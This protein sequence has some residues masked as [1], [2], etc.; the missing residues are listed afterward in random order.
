MYIFC[1][2]FNFLIAGPYIY[3]HK[4]ILLIKI[5]FC[6]SAEVREK[7]DL[8]DTK[9]DDYFFYK[10]TSFLAPSVAHILKFWSDTPTA[11]LRICWGGNLRKKNN[12]GQ[13]KKK[14]NTIST[15]KVGVK[16][17]LQQL[18]KKKRGNGKRKLVE[19]V[20]S[21]FFSCLLSCFLL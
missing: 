14:E 1:R 5:C 13:E 11:W 19:S 9:Y 21:F 20:F 15:K 17:K 8:V 16:K 6:S 2:Q 4:L 7:L 10:T 3:I 12:N 18:W